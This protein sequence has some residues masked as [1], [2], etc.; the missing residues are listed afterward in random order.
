MFSVFLLPK[1]LVFQHASHWRSAR[2]ENV[3]HTNHLITT[4]RI[5]LDYELVTREE[6]PKHNL[7][8]HTEWDLNIRYQSV[9]SNNKNLTVW[10]QRH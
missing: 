5:N 6:R 1:S 2:Y 7:Y 3:K 9:I 10:Y 8:W 4:V